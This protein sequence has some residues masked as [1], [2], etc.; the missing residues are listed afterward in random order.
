MRSKFNNRQVHADGLT[1]DSLAEHRRWCELKLL[2]QGGAIA[3][4]TVHDRWPLYV[5]GVLVCHYESDFCYAENNKLVVEDV[6]GALTELYKLKK[7]MMRACWGI[8][9]VEIGA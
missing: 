2:Q 8:R 5:K 6:K 4:L 1:F 9:I 3:G 7:K